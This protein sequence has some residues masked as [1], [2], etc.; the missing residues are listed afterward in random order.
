MNEPV[1][2]LSVRA[3]LASLLLVFAP[4]PAAGQARPVDQNPPAEPSGAQESKPDEVPRFTDEV[5]VT[6]TR[7]ERLAGEVPISVTVIRAT[8]IEQAPAFAVDN[9]L[10]DVPGLDLPLGGSAVAYPA[11]QTLSM[12]GLGGNRA[13]VLLDGIPLNDPASGYVP[14]S[15]IPMVAI[16]RIEIARGA[17]A[18]LFGNYS[19]GGT[20][21]LFSKSLD[22]HLEAL[23]GY[24]SY[25]T[26]RV[27]M[28]AAKKFGNG[29]AV[30]AD[31]NRFKSDGFDRT[32]A[33]LRG[34]ID[35]PVASDN[36]V[37]RLR[38]A[39]TT[40]R[41]Y[42]FA[43]ASV[44][45]EDLSL[46]TPL[47]KNTRDTFDVSAGTR[48]AVAS[49]DLSATV[50]HGHQRF[51]VQNTSLI[52]RDSEF[53]LNQRTSPIGDTGAAFQWSTVPGGRFSFFTTGI[54][55]RHIDLTEDGT[56][57][58]SAGA[59]TLLQTIGG[60]QDFAGVFA[61]TSMTLSPRLE[62]LATGRIDIWR[63]HDGFDRRNVGESA[64]YGSQRSTVFSPRVALRYR[65]SSAAS[66]R[67]AMYRAFR[68]P[69]I[70]DLYRK[71]EAKALVTVP[72]PGLGPETLVGGD[73]GID[74]RVAGTTAMLNFFYN[75]ID[76][77]IARIPLETSPVLVQQPVNI[78]RSRSAGIEAMASRQI[79]RDWSASAAL[80]LSDPVTL[81]NPVD[82][83]LEGKTT[84][85]ISRH[86]ES[87]AIHYQSGSGPAVVLRGRHVGKRYVD[88]ANQ[89]LLDA[90]LV[91]DL[92]AS[93]PLTRWAEL[94]M[95]GENLFGA[96]YLAEVGAARR[97]GAPLE[98]F[99]GVRF[100]LSRPTP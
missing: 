26:S 60:T 90:H 8:Q 12:R 32:P 83:L 92:H 21:Q 96:A 42:S 61:E 35:I 93:Y 36:S 37:V 58:D 48:V 72:N 24:G 47:S 55:L 29:F 67:G 23:A 94:F 45:A 7:T 18:S 16:D 95:T 56:N 62:V 77:L 87:I 81:S 89:L 28:S 82:R 40:S 80:T 85:G 70:A 34:P 2:T 84:A 1:A 79:G 17:A 4:F 53:L 25:G 91:F 20:V 78:G 88:A 64:M 31:V 54:D 63:N 39:M 22:D 100:R 46:G 65:L 6:A 27:A 41:T 59:V 66:L 52:R 30:G 68:A 51:W 97:L 76:G 15:K 49:G 19:L 9:L 86:M 3:V 71:T 57:Y 74:A 14:W 75:K 99:S 38:T 73:V 13:L 10:R 69:T 11:Q 98:L 50:F 33:D 44:F 43:V 5:V